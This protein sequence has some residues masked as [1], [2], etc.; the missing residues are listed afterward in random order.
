MLTDYSKPL[1][2]VYEDTINFY[3][4]RVEL[5][6]KFMVNF[7]QM[8]QRSFRQEIK[9]TFNQA[10]WSTIKTGGELYWIF[11]SK[12]WKCGED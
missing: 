11:G 6:K 4:S 8:L 12:C 3:E 2:K 1:F 9:H 10:G 5:D 7:G